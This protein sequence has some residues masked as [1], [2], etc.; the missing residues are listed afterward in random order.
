MG[1]FDRIRGGNPFEKVKK[2]ELQEEMIKLEREEKLKIA[3]L[4]KLSQ[5]KKEKF[6]RGFESS[7]AERRSL[8]REIQGLDHRMRLAN[9][10]LKKISDQIRVL[11]NMVFIKENEDTLKD[12]GVMSQLVKMPKSDLDRFLAKVNVEDKMRDGNIQGLI[13]TMESEYGLLGEPVEDKGTEELV[14]LWKKSDMAEADE[15]YESWEKKEAKKAKEE[16]LEE[17]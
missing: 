6:N 2:D 15:V 13:S 3:E 1:I 9:V 7:E 4:N 14:D 17:L 10:R 8:A 11:D 16:N 12:T 5:Q